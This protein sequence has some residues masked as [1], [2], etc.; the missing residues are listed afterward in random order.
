MR[1]AGFE[2]VYA[3][4]DEDLVRENETKTSAVHFLRFEFTAAMIA[5][6]H[7]P[8][9]RSRPASIIRHIVTASI[10]C[11][12]ACGRH[13]SPISAEPQRLTRLAEPVIGGIEPRALFHY[14][15]R[16]LGS[17]PLR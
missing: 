4:A 2:P 13:C 10:R 3:I 16:A 6:A 14:E 8:A 9:P 5:H 11:R 15:I 7:V 17:I 1:V 12:R